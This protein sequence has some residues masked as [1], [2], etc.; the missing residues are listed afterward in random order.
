M[1][2]RPAGVLLAACAALAI[3]PGTARAQSGDAACKDKLI[4]RIVQTRLS[5]DR[6]IGQFR[7]IAPRKT[8]TRMRRS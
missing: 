8:R 2:A 5:V 6:E 4:T 7:T 1:S 3:L